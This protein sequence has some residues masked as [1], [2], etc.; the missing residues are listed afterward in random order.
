MKYRLTLALGLLSP[1]L[2][3]AIPVVSNVSASQRANS[4]LV[5]ILYEVTDLENDPVKVSVEIS[6]DG[7]VTY[8]VPARTFT[9]AYGNNIPTGPGVKT[10]VWDAGA[11]WDG[12]YSSQMRVKIIASDGK[13][14]PGLEWGSEIPAGGFLM[15]QD[16]GAEGA[17]P[18][19]H[20]NIPWSYWLSKYEITNEQYCQYLNIAIAAGDVTRNGTT[21]VLGVTGRYP[22]VSAGATLIN[23]GSDIRWNVNKFE[24][25]NNRT[26]FPVRVPWSGAMAFA[27]HFGFDLPTDAEWEKA[28]RG[29]DHE[30]AG[31]HLVYPWG[32][33]LTGANANYYNSADLYESETLRITPVGYYDGNQIPVG[34][35]MNPNY[36]LFD[37]IGNL[38]E[39]TRTLV[40]VTTENYPSN[41]TLAS[42]A[43]NLGLTGSRSLRGGYYNNQSN[44]TELRIWRRASSGETGIRLIRRATP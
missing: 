41:E 18:S 2:L 24:V 31:E 34:N 27:Q 26:N 35:S 1:A 14:F 15:G 28:A 33:T 10:I 40:S 9:G 44:E 25:I 32:N 38:A 29:P 6:D 3:A 4:K 8:Q 20:V 42:S 43:H 30:E 12:E 13:G 39:H 23:L 17:G 11:D 37:Q 36:G 7:G 5:D 16:G 22:G 19:K 21:E